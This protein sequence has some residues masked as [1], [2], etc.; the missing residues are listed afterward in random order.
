[1]RNNKKRIAACAVT[2]ALLCTLNPY[3]TMTVEAA[4]NPTAGWNVLMIGTKDNNWKTSLA[5]FS[6]NK[7]S[8]EESTGSSEQTISAAVSESTVEATTEYTAP[9]T[10]TVEVQ[11]ETEAAPAAPA[12]NPEL[13][14]KVI[15]TVSNYQNIRESA[16]EDSAI[17]GRLF[18]G[19]AGTV[20]ETQGEWIHIQ[21]GSVDGWVHSDY[22]VSG[23]EAQAYAEKYISEIATV[24]EDGVRIREE[25]S[26]DAAKIETVD[27]GDRFEVKGSSESIMDEQGVSWTKIIYNEEVA[28]ICSDYVDVTFSLGK[29]KSIE[30]IEAEEKAA[31]EK[32]AAEKKAAEEKAAAEKKA[33]EE[34]AA[35]E[36]AA[37]EK[38]AAEKAAAEKAAAEKAAAAANESGWVSLGEFK[39]T[40][41]CG[42]ACC[43]GKWA[44]T[45]SSGVTPAEG[46]TI[47]VAPW[48]IPYGTQ[49]KIAGLGSTYVAED[50]GGFAYRNDHQI[51]LFVASHS[52]ANSWGVTYREVWIKK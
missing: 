30:E 4:T 13:E 39:I 23:E 2:G 26:S 3:G 16:S 40:A 37:A 14:N 29:A 41:Y 34:K 32:A 43:N 11:E 27:Q 19:G 49:V 52:A 18:A 28:Y 31:A 45:T 7:N 8:I 48:V 9:N 44:G 15:T 5:N 10:E 12:I 47:A 6:L 46:R 25:A 36:K 24:A 22:V 38:A 1:M 33:A 51:D 17:V 35:A 20:I 50:T 42:G 21:S